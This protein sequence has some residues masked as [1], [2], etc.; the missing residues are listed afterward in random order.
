MSGTHGLDGNTWCGMFER[1]AAEDNRIRFR[2]G[3]AYAF[4]GAQG[5][6]E[7]MTIRSIPRLQCTTHVPALVRTRYRG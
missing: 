5:R 2:I 4:P 7:F 6:L 3:S 1:R